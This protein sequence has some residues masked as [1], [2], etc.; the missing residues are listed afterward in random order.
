M[1]KPLPD[2]VTRAEVATALRLSLRQ[3][4]RL[5]KSGALKKTKLSASRSGFERDDF[6]RYLQSIG[7]GDGYVSPVGSFSFSLPAQSSLS[8]NAVAKKLD[9]IFAKSLPGCLVKAADSEIHIIW[10][11]A[12]GYTPEQILESL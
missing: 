3:V 2:H 9:E 8:C 6:D 4:D 7:L 5:A 12:L 10:N 1:G 11:A